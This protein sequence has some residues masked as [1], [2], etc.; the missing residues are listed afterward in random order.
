MTAYE[1]YPEF[2]EDWY[3][4]CVGHKKYSH[5]QAVLE[6]KDYAYQM[7]YIG[8]WSGYVPGRFAENKKYDVDHLYRNIIKA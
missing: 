2:Y 1:Q 8:C 4:F 7:A 3:Q 6:A 5:E